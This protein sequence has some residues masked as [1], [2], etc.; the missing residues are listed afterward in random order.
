MGPEIFNQIL[1]LENLKELIFTTDLLLYD[2]SK[3]VHLECFDFTIKNCKLKKQ[4]YTYSHIPNSDYLTDSTYTRII[5]PD[6]IKTLCCESN[7]LKSLDNLP[8]KLI[9]LSCHGNKITS[10]DN[11]PPLLK[12]KS[13]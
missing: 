12:C 9:R 4:L 3:L 7:K 8:F 2:L 6:N 11:L 10:L 5:I 1:F 13:N